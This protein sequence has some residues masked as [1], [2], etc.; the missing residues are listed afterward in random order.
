MYRINEC[1]NVE[2]YVRG[3]RSSAKGKTTNFS[4][5]GAALVG[6]GE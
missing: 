3:P 6:A 2:G 4:G 5:A 1:P